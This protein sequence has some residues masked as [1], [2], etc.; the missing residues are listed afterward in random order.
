MNR[1]LSA[2]L[3]ADVVGF[4]RMMGA[5]EA[6]TMAALK[7][8]RAEIFGPVFADH[9]GTIV[10]SMGDGWLVEFTSSVA[11]VSAAM[12]VQDRLKGHA[13]ITLRMGIHIGDVTRNEDDIYGDGIN[14]AARLEAL[15]PP[16]SVL[17]SDAVYSSLDGTLSPSFEA[18]GTQKLKNITRPIIT[19][20]RMSH[21]AVE[22]ERT[23]TAQDVSTLP[24]LHIHPTINN[25]P[26]AELQD[27]ADGLTADL[28][29]YFGGINWLQTK[30]SGSETTEAYSLRQTLRA[31]GDRL[32][33][34]TRLQNDRGDIIWTHKSDSTLDDAFDWQDSVVADIADHCLGMI[35]EAETTRLTTIPDD[36]L[37]AEQCVLMGIMAWR[38][39]GHVS[40]ANS[41]AF[42]ERAIK[43]KPDLADAYAE[44]VIVLVAAQTMS[45]KPDLLAYIAKLPAWVEAG[46]ALAPGHPML[47]LS[48][49]I[50]TYLQDQR[51]LPLKDVVAQTLRLA[52]FDA[53]ILGY[54]G[55]ANL[56]S[57]QTQDAFDCFKKSLDF[58][59]RGPAY[60]ASLGG[61]ASACV[62]LGRDED[63]LAY[64][65]K[66]L[67]LTDNYPTYFSAKSAALANL[68]RIQEAQEAMVHYR[69]L[70]PDR[71]IRLWQATNNYAGCDGGKRF[72]DG[73]ILAG[74]PKE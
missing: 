23:D 27:I 17:I 2:V 62:Q 60:V 1:K 54:C 39:F 58:G 45:R 29:T 63:A 56:W 15:S 28:G 7:T 52:P 37:T 31:R 47:T 40:F 3:A 9:K 34:E 30:I 66:G 43:A 12:Q 25:D 59:R 11:A 74:L 26:R 44:G 41:V 13:E 53:R 57:G 55:W 73:L 5:N 33:L 51:P 64:V 72:F 19:W 71:T 24:G 35:L 70:E 32:R 16:G 50:A 42:F 65:K 14:I 22:R 4:S 10:K 48:I 21:T 6:A 61:I 46:R 38:D 68:G 49:A 20:A 67:A 69:I 36:Q 18:A 8:L